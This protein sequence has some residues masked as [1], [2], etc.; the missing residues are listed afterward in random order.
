MLFIG[1]RGEGFRELWGLGD[2]Q[3]PIS[4]PMHGKQIPLIPIKKIEF[5]F[6]LKK[7]IPIKYS[8]PQNPLIY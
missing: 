7:L 8:I 4:G 6:H 3:V 2:R 1:G 5:L